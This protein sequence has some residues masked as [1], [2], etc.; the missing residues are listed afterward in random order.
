MKLRFEPP[1]V[2]ELVLGE[3]LRD[4]AFREEVRSRLEPIYNLPPEARAQG[5]AQAYQALFEERGLGAGVAQELA[6][7]PLLAP[8]EQVLVF[9]AERASEVGAELS[10]DRRIAGIR[11]RLEWLTHP[12]QLRLFLGH[13]LLGLSDLLD[14]AFGY[15]PQALGETPAEEHLYRQRYSLLWDIYID[16]RLERGGLPPAGGRGER[17]AEYEH[18]FAFLPIG[19]REGFRRLYEGEGIT[20]QELVAL[21]REPGR[22]VGEGAP[23]VLPP[24]PGAPCPLCRFPTYA[25]GDPSPVV[26]LIEGDFPEW[27]PAQGACLR[28]VELYQLR[29]GVW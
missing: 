17:L 8:L 6:R 11:V 29:A 13:E 18:H 19:R 22:L 14:Q 26:K 12:E 4:L 20:H 10:R 2:Q 9:R 1:L 3:T 25:W 24:T 27:E 28:C 5:F 16:G 7:F 21:A 23:R 15:L